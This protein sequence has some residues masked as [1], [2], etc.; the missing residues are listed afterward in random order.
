[1][2]QPGYPWPETVAFLWYF[3]IVHCVGEQRSQGHFFV[4]LGFIL[5]AKLP[6]RD[7]G[8]NGQLE[9]KVA[10]AATA[11]AAAAVAVAVAVTVTVTVQ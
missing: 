7:M 3:Q 8:I 5:R 9:E 2:P 6:D 1:M 11:A 10:E 4:S